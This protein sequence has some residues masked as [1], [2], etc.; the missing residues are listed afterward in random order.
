MGKR[1]IQRMAGGGADQGKRSRALS[2]ISK[3]KIEKAILSLDSTFNNTRLTLADDT[4]AT[5]MWSS[6]GSLGF[7]GTRKGT[8]FA[9]AKVGEV[10]GEKALT[11]GVKEVDVFVKGIGSGRESALRA[12]AGKGI[13]VSAI[14][15]VTP[16]PHN[17]PRPPKPRRV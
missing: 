16:V 12:F 13:Q 9:A 17:G 15:D 2:K 10:I 8:P 7:A 4:G 14:H 6:A 3:R 11:V 1:R 5:I